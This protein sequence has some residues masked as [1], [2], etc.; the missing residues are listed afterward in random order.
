MIILVVIAAIVLI[1]GIFY[2][3]NSWQQYRQWKLATFIVVLSLAGVIYGTIN[4]PYWHQKTSSS[5]SE[6]ASASS[7]MSSS[8]LLSSS[9]TANQSAKASYILGQLQKNFT[10]LGTVSYDSKTKTYTI[11]PSGDDITNALSAL[12]S[13][14]SYAD[15]I[16]WPNLTSNLQKTSQSIQKSIGD[17]YTLQLMSP[18]DNSKALL[19]VKDGQVTYNI[20][21]TS[22]STSSSSN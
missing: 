4:L 9:T 14:T 19:A 13:D 8:S 1:L 10:K 7:L 5:A 2:L 22:S 11:T 21:D 16:G 6:S 17:G 20:V 3:V 15:Q 12:E 18:N